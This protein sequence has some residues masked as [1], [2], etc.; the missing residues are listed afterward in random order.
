MKNKAAKAFADAWKGK[1]YE[2]G[3]TQRFWTTL[4]RDVLGVGRPEERIVFEERVKVDKL[5]SSES[6]T[7]Y[8]DARIPETKV[9][10]EQKSS[11]VD[12]RA[13]IRQSDGFLLTPYQQAKKYANSLPYSER[14]RWIVTCNFK[15]FL[16]YD[17]ETPNSEPVDISIDDFET[18]AYRLEFLVKFQDEAIIRETQISIQ[19]GEIVGKLYDALRSG[20][21]Y[22]DAPSTLQSLNV[23]PR[24]QAARH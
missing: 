23:C 24:R 18:E 15:E 16:I 19:A 20:Y 9:L 8:I 5:T 7:N 11:D 17:M 1:G 10:I 21:V 12:L 6:Q 2:K 22:P 4:L 13:P 3:E 14:P